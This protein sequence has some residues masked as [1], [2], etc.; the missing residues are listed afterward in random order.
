MPAKKAAK[1]TT[2]PVLKAVPD[3]PSR[4]RQEGTYRYRVVCVGIAPMLQNPM[5]D[6]QLDTL[7]FGSAGRSKAVNRDK[8]VEDIAGERVCKDAQGR[9]GIPSNY[10]FAS[11]IDAGRHVVFEKKTKMSTRESSL[12]PAFLSIVDP[13]TGQ[14]AEFLPFDDQ[15]AGWVPDKRK[16]VLKNA[17]GG[18][19]VCIVRPKFNAWSFTAHVDV[20][21]DQVNIDKV[22]DVFK[23]AGM[24]SGLGDFRPSHK[25]PFGRFRVVEFSQVCKVDTLEEAA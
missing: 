24:Y 2:A 13:D 3:A 15:T 10:L 16:G 4:G 23:K 8:R 18:V 22:Q 14:L 25:G 11:L 19:A 1:D 5:T 12:I 21:L 9:F 7:L 20:D 17:A 6:E